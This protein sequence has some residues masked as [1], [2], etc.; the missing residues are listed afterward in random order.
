M[1]EP[2]DCRGGTTCAT[3]RSRPDA[4]AAL[5][6]LQRPQRRATAE[7][8]LP[9]E[10]RDRRHGAVASPRHRQEHG[11]PPAEHP[12]R[13]AAPR[14]GSRHRRLPTRAGDVRAGRLGLDAHRP[15]RGLLPRRRPAPQRDPRDRAGRGARRSRGRVRR[16]AREPADPAPVR[17][18]RS[19]QRRALHEQRQAPARV[20]LPRSRL[21]VVLDGWVLARTDRSSRSRDQSRLRQELAAIRARGWAENINEVE[22]GVA[23]VAAPIRNG[24]NE[25]VA[26][27]S[28]AGPLAA[29]H[30]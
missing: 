9:R 7:G 8:V 24:L 13:G 4:Q 5:H 15:A 23:S 1:T 17:A 25:V 19:S 28:V 20:P 6:A 2:T 18:G 16:A 26:S 10:P 12:R 14:A 22:I 27:V 3:T 30:Q 21:D 11:A 29:H